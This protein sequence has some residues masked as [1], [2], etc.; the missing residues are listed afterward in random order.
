MS[1]RARGRS[2]VDRAAA[3]PQHARM[4][5]L[6]QKRQMGARV[7]ACVVVASA[8]TLLLGWPVAC[9]QG[10]SHGPHSAATAEVSAH[11]V[12][13]HAATV[14]VM[15]PGSAPPPSVSTAA[16]SASNIDP[17]RGDGPMGY[18]SGR[19]CGGK[20]YEKREFGILPGGKF[21]AS[22]L[23]SPPPTAYLTTS[24][25]HS[26]E[27][28]IVTLDLQEVGRPGFPTQLRYDATRDVMLDETVTPPCAYPRR[29]R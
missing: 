11:T 17:R 15:N 27:G 8:A 26:I 23:V 24:G 13:V 19:R 2:R 22:E 7:G 1:T 28:H 21:V 6:S 16:P 3:A 25:T 4:N 12:I 18:W 29:P 14:I 20:S 10:P 9:S 5:P